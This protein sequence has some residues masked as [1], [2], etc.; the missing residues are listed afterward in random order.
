MPLT[1]SFLVMVNYGEHT[2]TI[3]GH[4]ADPYQAVLGREAALRKSGGAVT[5]IVEELDILEAYRRADYQRP[6]QSEPEPT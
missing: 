4:Y 2:W 6:K 5:M 1:K 3:D